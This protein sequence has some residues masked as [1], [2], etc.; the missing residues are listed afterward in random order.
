[1]SRKVESPGVVA[2]ELL[3]RVHA[4]LVPELDRLVGEVCGVPL[5]WYDVLL[6]LNRAPDRRLRMTEL[7]ERVVLSRSRVSR[8]V[9]AMESEGLVRRE[10]D[11]ED[12]RATLALLTVH[13][14]ETLRQAAPGYLSGIE[15]M[16]SSR[17]TLEEIEVISRALASVLEPE[18]TA[19]PEG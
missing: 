17:L 11:P 2:W 1:M 4:A 19:G 14:R 16:F 7:G 15:R 6:E 5:S 12:R 9:D 3:L 18:S 8:I 13:G 10:P